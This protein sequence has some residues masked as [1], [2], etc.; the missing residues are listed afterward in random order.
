MP[1]DGRKSWG[2]TLFADDLRQEVGNKFSLMG[3]YQIDMLLQQDLPISLPK[4][5]MLI[6]YYEIKGAFKDALNVKIFLPGNKDDAPQLSW[7][8]DGATRDSAKSPYESA[9]ADAEKLFTLTIPVILTPLVINEEGFIKVRVQCG[10]TTTRLGRL[11]IRK[12]KPADQPQFNP[13]PNV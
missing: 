5:A 7:Q 3:V 4:F 8:I 2:V 12:I 13:L 10:D 11:M 1:D 9:D 6:N